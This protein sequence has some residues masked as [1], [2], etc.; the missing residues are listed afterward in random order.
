MI[1]V[2]SKG[3]VMPDDDATE[4]PEEPMACS[5]PY[6]EL[7]WQFCNLMRKRVLIVQCKVGNDLYDAFNWLDSL[8][9]DKREAGLSH[10][11]FFLQASLLAFC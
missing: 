2:I 8:A 11:A 5:D 7:A 1:I 3:C 9:S 10:S 6:K 4:N